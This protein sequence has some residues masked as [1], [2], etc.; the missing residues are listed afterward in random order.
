MKI[1]IIGKNSN[2]SRHFL[3]KFNKDKKLEVLI[4]SLRSNFSTTLK[5]NKSKKIIIKFK[6]KFI[7]NCS[8]MTTYAY[9]EKYPKI[10]YDVNSILC[11]K[12]SL[13]CEKK[14]IYFIHFSTDAV[15]SG[16][17]NKLYKVNDIP[18][19]NTV[20]GK[21][22]LYGE[23]LISPHYYSLI[24]RLPLIFGKHFESGFL[25]NTIKKI[26]SKKKFYLCKDMFC[27]PINADD[28]AKYIYDN[29]I[30]K[31]NIKYFLRKKII[32]LSSNKQIS[33]Y[34]FI[35]KIYNCKYIKKNSYK[36]LNLKIMP[37]KYSG[38][39]S[40]VINCVKYFD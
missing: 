39:K 33:R 34:D 10:A 27:S 6:P 25:Y 26:K 32:H 36:D 16:I 40:N 20:M 30:K 21:S 7:F 22:K 37:N 5:F 12:L 8:G 15:F 38:L 3:D 28:V 9:C 13:L 18:N 23:K 19:P 35:K 11:Y 31:N 1:L 14:N 29:L 2:L 4:L 17:E 24:I